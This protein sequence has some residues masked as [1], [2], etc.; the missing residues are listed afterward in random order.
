MWKMSFNCGNV[1]RIFT[2]QLSPRSLERV[3][4]ILQMER[5][6]K[7]QIH[8]WVGLH[9][10]DRGWAWNIWLLVKLKLNFNLGN[11][12]RRDRAVW[13]TSWTQGVKPHIWDNR[14]FF[15]FI[16]QYRSNRSKIWMTFLVKQKLPNQDEVTLVKDFLQRWENTTKGVFILSQ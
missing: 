10:E 13:E 3:K 5:C 16:L 7:F 9:R 6:E 8:Q 14:T 4:D 1:F 2:K 15:H 11:I 12:C